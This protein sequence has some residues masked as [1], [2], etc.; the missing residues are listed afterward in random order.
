MDCQR[1]D[2]LE[3]GMIKV[4]RHRNLGVEKS[5]IRREYRLLHSNPGYKDVISEP[6]FSRSN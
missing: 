6:R 4:G 3:D 5:C 1:L 2:G